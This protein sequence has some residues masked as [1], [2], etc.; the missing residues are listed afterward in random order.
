MVGVGLEGSES[1]L[2]RVLVVNAYGN[3]IYDKFVAAREK[4][5]DYRTA[6]SGIRPEDIANG[7]FIQF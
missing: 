4:V 3:V 1:M 5:E 6:V 7:T 2:A